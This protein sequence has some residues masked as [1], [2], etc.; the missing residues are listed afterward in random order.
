MDF[1]FENDEVLGKVIAYFHHV[2]ILG[3]KATRNE[4]D[5][6]QTVNEYVCLL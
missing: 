3:S 5:N 1:D 6:N 4:C 2:Q